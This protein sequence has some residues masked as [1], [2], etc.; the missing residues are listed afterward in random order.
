MTNVSS[1]QS[2]K[3]MA[4]LNVSKSHSKA[5]SAYRLYELSPLDRL[6]EADLWSEHH[7]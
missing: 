2:R 7:G 5:G 4:A 6:G 3:A 1:I